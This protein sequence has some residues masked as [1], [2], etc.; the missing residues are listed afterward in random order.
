MEQARR[1]TV[2]ELWR[3][4]SRRGHPGAE[5]GG[6]EPVR[7]E[8]ARRRTEPGNLA[9]EPQAG[10]H[11]RAEHGAAEHGP[12]EHGPAEHERA[13]PRRAGPT[14]LRPPRAEPGSP[15]PVP[16]PVELRRELARV[17]VSLLEALILRDVEALDTWLGEEFVLTTAC[18]GPGVW[19][20]AECL[21]MARDE[22]ALQSFGIKEVAV[23]PYHDVA[24]VRVRSHRSGRWGNADRAATYWTT[25]VFVRR[26]NDW[27]LVTRHE[28]EVDDG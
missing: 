9:P 26:D 3:R 1:S 10:E 25:D 20:R 22:Y 27:R 19:S 6:T 23:E 14:Q 17:E 2:H 18:R 28:T 5:P 8:R 12:A 24:V 4:A 21:R 11:E 13:E 15:E 7:S 16:D